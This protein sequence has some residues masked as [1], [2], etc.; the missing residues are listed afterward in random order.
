MVISP[1]IIEKRSST[2]ITYEVNLQYDGRFFGS[3][4]AELVMRVPAHVQTY[5]KTFTIHWSDVLATI[6][7]AATFTIA[8]TIHIETRFANAFG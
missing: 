6:G 8:G 5:Q 2:D 4:A 1:V 7:G 3:K